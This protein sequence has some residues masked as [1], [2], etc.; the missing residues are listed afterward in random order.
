MHRGHAFENPIFVLLHIYVCSGER[1]ASN[2][3]AHRMCRSVRGLAAGYINNK[4]NCK[5]QPAQL[6][7]IFPLAAQE[8]ASIEGA[9]HVS[10]FFRRVHEGL[11]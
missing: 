11:M 7:K 1:K 4:T 3:N 9:M 10:F 2:I 5:L 8:R 6:C